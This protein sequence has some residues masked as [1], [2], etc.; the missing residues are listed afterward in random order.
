V[1]V[2]AAKKRRKPVVD[3][4]A[5]ELIRQMLEIIEDLIDQNERQWNSLM[6][7]WVDID[8][9]KDQGKL[10]REARELEKELGIK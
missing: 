10:A 4:K 9:L 7:A 3:K 1:I 2:A 8:I 6:S 5:R